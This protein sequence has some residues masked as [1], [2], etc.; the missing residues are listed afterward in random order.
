[1]PSTDGPRNGSIDLR[2]EFATAL[3]CPEEDNEEREKVSLKRNREVSR[4]SREFLRLF[5]SLEKSVPSVK[6]RIPLRPCGRF[7]DGKVTFFTPL[8]ITKAK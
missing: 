3:S 6:K 1:M 5:F 8:S 2:G 7:S 4:T